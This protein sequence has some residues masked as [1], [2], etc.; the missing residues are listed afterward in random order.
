MSKKQSENESPTIRG[1]SCA[2]PIPVG[3]EW[4]AVRLYQC[5]LADMRT[6]SQKEQEQKQKKDL[7][8]RLSEQVKENE[9]KRRK[10]LE[11]EREEAMQARKDYERYRYDT[12]VNY[13]EKQRL[14]KELRDTWEQQVS[15]K[16]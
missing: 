6:K 13:Q 9:E 1:E 3:T 11:N 10:D 5:Y 14:A 4:E 16:S 12:G 15:K 8:Q 2:T 7:A